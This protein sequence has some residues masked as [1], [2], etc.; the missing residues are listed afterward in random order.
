M[1]VRPSKMQQLW[2]AS[3]KQISVIFPGFIAKKAENLFLTL[4]RYQRP[5]N[6]NENDVYASA[7]KFTILDG[8]QIYHGSTGQS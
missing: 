2:F 8:L 3:W 6:E 7:K 4:I 5:E 1:F